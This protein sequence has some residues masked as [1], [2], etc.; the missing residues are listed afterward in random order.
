MLQGLGLP[1]GAL[2]LVSIEYREV[3]GFSA[4]RKWGDMYSE[5]RPGSG[6]HLGSEQDLRTVT[7]KP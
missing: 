7:P 2:N 3:E 5:T 1:V 6:K 4:L